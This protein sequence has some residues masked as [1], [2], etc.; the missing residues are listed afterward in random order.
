MGKNYYEVLSL[1]R[2]DQ[3]SQDLIQFLWRISPDGE[4]I[5]QSFIFPNHAR[6]LYLPGGF[7]EE[8]VYLLSDLYDFTFEGVNQQYHHLFVKPLAEESG[9]FSFD[10]HV[11]RKFIELVI[12]EKNVQFLFDNEYLLFQDTFYHLNLKQRK[13]VGLF[14]IFQ[15]NLI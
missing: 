14:E 7:F 15:L 1:L 5:D 3:A 8:G 10:V 9:L 6:H 2:F 4:K 12:T 13:I 11:H